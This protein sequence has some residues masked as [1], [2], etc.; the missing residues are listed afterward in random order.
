MYNLLCPE[1]EQARLNRARVKKD[2]GKE[3]Y[4]QQTHAV[5][6][7]KLGEAKPE[8]VV[9]GELPCV[10]SGQIQLDTD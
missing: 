6:Q 9:V 7:W 1:P 10:G 4:N 8:S 5:A 3:F 2:Y